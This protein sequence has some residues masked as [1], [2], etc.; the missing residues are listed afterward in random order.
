[1]V[2]AG[3]R[4]CLIDLYS[5]I[6]KQMGVVNLGLLSGSCAPNNPYPLFVTPIYVQIDDK[7]LANSLFAS[8]FDLILT[9]LI[10]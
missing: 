4:T 3:S 6:F 8:Q 1:M 5:I 9:L 7:L 10:E 2:N